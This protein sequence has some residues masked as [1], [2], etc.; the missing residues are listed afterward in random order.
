VAGMTH[1]PV[2]IYHENGQLESKGNL[3]MGEA[4]R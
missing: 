1:G 3:N 4:V 2:E